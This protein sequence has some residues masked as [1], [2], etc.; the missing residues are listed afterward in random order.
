[1]RIGEIL[2]EDSSTDNTLKLSAILN[3][4]AGRVGDTGSDEPVSLT[5][6]LNI[7][8]DAGLPIDERE[9]RDMASS[10]PLNNTIANISG[11]SVTFLGQRKDTSGAIKPDQTTGTLEKMAKRAAGKRN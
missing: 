5:A 7:L 2:N 6:I 3:Q 4:I 10:S 11:D 9:F 8:N 1:M